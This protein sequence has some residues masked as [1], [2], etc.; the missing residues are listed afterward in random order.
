MG[1][2]VSN[3]LSLMTLMMLKDADPMT[4]E[5][6]RMAILLQHCCPSIL[7]LLNSGWRHQ[8]GRETLSGGSAGE[9]ERGHRQR[10]RR[11][12]H[13]RRQRQR[14]RRNVRHEAS[15][16]IGPWWIKIVIIN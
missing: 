12:R 11:R 4:S 5:T 10:R 3:K 6:Y 2:Y 1:N 7:A 8:A 9:A 16:A 15:L 14:R 13:G